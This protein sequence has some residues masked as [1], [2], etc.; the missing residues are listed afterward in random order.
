MTSK[1]TPR[2]RG[3]WTKKRC[4]DAASKCASRK[5][6]HSSSAGVIASRKGWVTECL[7]LIP[8]K[9]KPKGYWTLERCKEDASKFKTRTQ[10]ARAKGGGYPVAQKQGW[11][12]ACC[13]HM[14][15]RS[16]KYTLE[17]C[18]A[19]AQ[20]FSGTNE[21]QKNSRGTL[22]AAHYYGW[23]DQ[24]LAVMKKKPGTNGYWT[25]ERCMESAR[26]FEYKVDW[27]KSEPAAA[28]AAR[29]KGWY[30]D[31]VQHM[32]T[33]RLGVETTWTLEVCKKEASKYQTKAEW[34]KG[35][36][37]TYQAARSRGWLD[38]CGEHMQLVYKP[39]GYWTLKKCKESAAKFTT[40]SE[41]RRMDGPASDFAHRH[42][43][44]DE[45]CAHME[46]GY[47]ASDDDAI[48]LW[49]ADGLF[50]DGVQV[51]K[52]GRTSSRLGRQRIDQVS[53]AQKLSAEIILLA[54]TEG[55]AKD[56]ERKLL[57]FGE[58]VPFLTGDGAT[59]FRALTEREL[60]RVKSE[61][62]WGCIEEIEP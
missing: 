53:K 13:D 55:K 35:H 38:I 10:W 54:K 34:E 4:L 36:R 59:E 26:S 31:C 12:D 24:C 46:L 20:K 8:L 19:D 17:D 9:G 39:A 49:R 48:Y 62:T 57:E 47:T 50:F 44:V 21:W 60:A 6:F 2:P 43:W 1:N 29:R 40:Q 32:K 37:N 5:E 15:T 33:D 25:K 51:Y 56:L 61:I 28:G 18:L 52:I 42:G 16:S 23:I 30:L 7:K 14:E 27:Q 41:W 11:I 22:R 45:C 3:Y 58:P